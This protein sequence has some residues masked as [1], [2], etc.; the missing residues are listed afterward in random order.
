M[1]G[2]MERLKEKEKKECEEEMRGDK[3]DMGVWSLIKAEGFSNFLWSGGV[4]FGGGKT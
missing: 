3:T 4:T 2:N 1:E